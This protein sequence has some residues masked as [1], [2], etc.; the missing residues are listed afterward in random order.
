MADDVPRYARGRGLAMLG[1]CT[2]APFP[3]SVRVNM[4]CRQLRISGTLAWGRRAGGLAPD[5]ATRKLEKRVPL[6]NVIWGTK[7]VIWNR[8]SELAIYV[9]YLGAQST[10]ITEQTKEC[11]CHKRRICQSVDSRCRTWVD[12]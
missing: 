6:Q 8:V 12:L 11:L 3:G 10:I 7:V 4:G 1:S 5:H 2:C 9:W